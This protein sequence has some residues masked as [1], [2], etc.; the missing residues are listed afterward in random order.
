MESVA[1]QHVLTRNLYRWLSGCEI[2]QDEGWQPSREEPPWLVIHLWQRVRMEYEDQTHGLF[3]N[4]FILIITPV[5]ILNYNWVKQKLERQENMI[6][7]KFKIQ[8]IKH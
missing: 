7:L 2:K 4:Y 6:N 5:I 3:A 8:I 1:E